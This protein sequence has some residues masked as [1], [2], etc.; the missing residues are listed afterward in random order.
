MDSPSGETSASISDGLELESL[1]SQSLFVALT[2]VEKAIPELLLSVKPILSHLTTSTAI[3]GPSV[4][5]TGADEEISGIRAREGVERYMTLLDK[6]QF[7][8]RQTVYYLHATKIPSSTLSP[9]S[10]D[11]IP[12]PFATT[13]S[14]SAAQNNGPRG[15]ELGLYANRIEE[16]VLSDMVDAIKGLKAEQEQLQHQQRRGNEDVNGNDGMEVEVEK[17][18][19][20]I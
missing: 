15:V 18:D 2:N 12:T 10:V 5:D 8:L 17:D 11:N 20:R 13:L 14:S 6:I 7:V 3:D 16:K 19:R 4:S 9:P 1:D